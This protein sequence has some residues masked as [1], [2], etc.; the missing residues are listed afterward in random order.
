MAHV[1]WTRGGE[2]DVTA[3]SGDRV[4]LRSSAPFAPGTPA[5][6]TLASGAR[7][8]VKVARCRRADEGGS[9][10]AIDGRLIDASRE[11]RVELARLAGTPAT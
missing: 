1:R 7:V 2:A 10:F 5:E 9:A 11:L 8:V 6:G 3:A 4:S